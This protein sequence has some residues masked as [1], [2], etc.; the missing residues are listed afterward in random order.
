MMLKNFMQ[1]LYQGNP[2]KE[3]EDFLQT[4]VKKNIMDQESILSVKNTG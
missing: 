3:G 2:F 4:L 1:S